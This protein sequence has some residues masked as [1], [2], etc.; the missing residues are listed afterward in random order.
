MSLAIVNIGLSHTGDA[1]GTPLSGDAVV[2]DDGLISWIGDSADVRPGDHET[3]IDA[4]GVGM[5]PGLIDSHVHSTFGDYTPRQQT[6]GFLESYVHG[7][8]TRA[9]SASE[10]HVPGRPTDPEGVKALAIAAQRAFRDFRPGGM[11]VHAGSV[12]LEP[13]LT[14]EDFAYLREQGVWLAKGGFGAVSAPRDYVPLVRD[15]RRAGIVVTFHTGG[16]SIP[17]TLERIDADLLLEMNPNVS[18]HANGG[19]TAMPAGDN[20]RLVREGEM[21]LQLVMAGNLRSSLDIC[22]LAHE[23]GQTGR[24]LI[25]SDTPTGTGVVPLALWHL[26]AELVSLGGLDVDQAIAAMTGQVADVFGLDAGRLEIGRPADLLLLD[27]PLGS[28]GRTWA[29]ALRAGD[30]PGVCAAVTSGVVRFD[31]SRNTPA[32]AR[33][34]TIHGQVAASS[35]GGH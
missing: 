22:R 11:T 34:I 8:V 29:D 7:G 9:I 2:C 3:V 12:I 4:A 19:P 25:A 31:K 26:S 15:A 13:G 23:H 24:I 5:V 16:G 32:A 1:G 28:V 6:V 20:E 27:A 14:Y 30:I 33:S 10:V 35:A 18:F 17:G 21:A